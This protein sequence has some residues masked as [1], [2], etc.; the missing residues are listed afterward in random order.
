VSIRLNTHVSSTT[1]ETGM[2]LLDEGS[3]RFWELNQTGTTV[4]QALVGG[5]TQ[6]H[7]VT[8][9]TAG[10]DATPDR[11]AADVAAFVSQ[12]ITHGLAEPV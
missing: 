12:L 6:Q 10:T 8:L 2:V 3:G 7:A 1:T 5:G 4:L 11:A 9:L